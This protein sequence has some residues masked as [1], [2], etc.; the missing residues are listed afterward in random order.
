[1]LDK[2][3]SHPNCLVGIHSRLIVGDAEKIEEPQISQS[4]VGLPMSAKALLVS[5][6]GPGQQL[7]GCGF[8]QASG[9][10]CRSEQ[11]DNDATLKYPNSTASCFCEDFQEWATDR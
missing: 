9:S 7:H 8:F 1:M 2:Y 11:N 3:N 10:S 5:P 6:Q 4:F